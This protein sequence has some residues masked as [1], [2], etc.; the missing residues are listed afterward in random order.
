VWGLN[1]GLNIGLECNYPLFGRRYPTSCANLPHFLGG[2]NVGG[3]TSASPAKN[4][5]TTMYDM[6][7]FYYVVCN[8]YI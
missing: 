6:Y 7:S 2:S 4:D 8:V 1:I 3:M 5:P